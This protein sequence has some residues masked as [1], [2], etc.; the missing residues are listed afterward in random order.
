MRLFTRGH[1]SVMA[2][3]S[4]AVVACFSPLHLSATTVVVGSCLSGYPQYSSI[5]GAVTAVSTV[6]TAIVKVCPGTYNEQVLITAQQTLTLEGVET[7]TS[8]APVILPPS[9]GLAQNG[10][11]INGNPV[12]AQIFVSSGSSSTVNVEHLTVDGTGNNVAS[13]GLNVEGIY[14]QNTPGTITYN[15]VRNQYD[16][17]YAT[18]G[19]CQ[20][21]MGINVESSSSSPSVTIS[22]NSVHTY[23]KNGITASGDSPTNSNGPLAS[24]KYNYIVGVGALAMNWPSSGAAGNGI[25]VGFGATGTVEYNEVS[26]NIWAQDTSSDTGDAATGILVFASNGIS[27]LNNYVSSSQFGIAIVT[28]GYG[29]C[30]T[31]SAPAS[32]GTANDATVTGN[33]VIGTQLF[34]AIDLCS[35]QNTAS[36]NTLYG[37]TE[38][39]VHI[40]DTCTNSAIGTT[41]GNNNNVTRNTIN[42]ACAGVLL[43]TGT[44]N[45]YT[46]NTDYNVP[47]LTLSGDTCTLATPAVPGAKSSRHQ[48]RRPSPYKSGRK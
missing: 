43:G 20:T 47:N 15:S 18:Y 14:Y 8:Y 41:S 37:N 35:N 27:V 16:T 13:C 6:P 11:D 36:T 17:D 30:G 10:T 44:H 48:T 1:R 29:Y 42:E 7:S 28:D 38:S 25:Q 5:Q 21:G 31:S 32:C 40:D 3:F 46:P 33:K 9:G 34:D 19:G 45:T 24:I 12:A 39:G 23:Q 22:Y 4:L 26:D 2:I